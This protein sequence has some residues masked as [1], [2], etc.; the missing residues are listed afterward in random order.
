MTFGDNFKLV[1]NVSSQHYDIMMILIV[2]LLTFI[3]SCML[4]IT[5]KVYRSD[6]I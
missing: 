2:I 1:Q 6:K 5:I 4:A 3:A